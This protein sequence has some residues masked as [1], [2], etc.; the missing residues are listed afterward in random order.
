MNLLFLSEQSTQGLFELN[1]LWTLVF[2]WINLLILYF[3]MKKFFFGKIEAVLD[4]RRSEVDDT[5]R[6][7][8]ETEAEAKAL[9][10]EYDARMAEATAKAEAIVSNAVKTARSK[11]TEIVSEARSKAAATMASAEAKIELDRQKAINEVKEDISVMAV[12][13]ATKVIEREIEAQ[14][15][16][17]LIEQMIEQL[18][19]EQE[20]QA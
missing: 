18:T 9:K 10:E 16:E 15:H 17:R 1:D 8:D 13:I 3:V 19:A 11:E 7:A 14:D 20:A 2:T 6:K 4:Q 5:Y 12:E